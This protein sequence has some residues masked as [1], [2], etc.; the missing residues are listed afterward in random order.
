MSTNRNKDRLKI[1]LKQH[2][3]CPPRVFAPKEMIL[4]IISVC[5]QVP[6]SFARVARREQMI[7]ERDAHTKNED[8]RET[9]VYL[10]T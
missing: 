9:G 2:F 4:M 1:L 7:C 6:K 5:C 10:R 8:T 3:Y